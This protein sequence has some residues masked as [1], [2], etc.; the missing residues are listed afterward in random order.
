MLT[1]QTLGIGILLA[2]LATACAPQVKLN[3]ANGNKGVDASSAADKAKSAKV[4]DALNSVGATT[5]DAA[6]LEDAAKDAAKAETE[7]SMMSDKDLL[8]FV[9]TTQD[10]LA[11]DCLLRK[12]QIAKD[13][14]ESQSCGVVLD[15]TCVGRILNED[16]KKAQE[17]AAK[18]QDL[19]KAMGAAAI[20]VS[21]VPAVGAVAAASLGAAAG[22]AIASTATAA[23]ATQAMIQPDHNSIYR[24]TI[25]GTVDYSKKTYTWDLKGAETTHISVKDDEWKTPVAQ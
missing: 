23:V 16:D 1:K 11:A 22:A 17:E 14:D 12:R 5:E 9:K 2:I 21:A 18:K 24:I 10:S 7:K 15:V 25:K 6:S 8:Q 19:A 13:C 20:S 3:A 4:G